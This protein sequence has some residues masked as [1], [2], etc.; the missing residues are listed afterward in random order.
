[1]IRAELHCTFYA[2]DFFKYSTQSHFITVQ[3]IDI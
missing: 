3:Q 2:E 1:M